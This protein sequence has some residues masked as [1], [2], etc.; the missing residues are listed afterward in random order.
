MRRETKV[1]IQGLAGSFHD[2]VAR[3][4]FGNNRINV[5][6]ASSFEGV[7]KILN[8]DNSIHYGVMAIENSIAG[9]LLQNYR[10]LRENDF[11]ISG[12]IYHKIQHQLLA[13][14]GQ[15]IEDINI[16]ESHPMALLQCTNFLSQ[17]EHIKVIESSNTAVS[18]KKISDNQLKGTAT[19]ASN[20]AAD[21]YGLEKLFENVQNKQINYTRFVVFSREP[22]YSSIGVADK[23]SIYI[24]VPHDKGSLL[25]AIQ[26]IARHDINISKLQSYPVSGELNTYYFH[27]DLEFKNIN[28]YESCIEDL[29]Q[30]TT[31][32]EE[33]GVYKNGI[34]APSVVVKEAPVLL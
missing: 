34:T 12:E 13:L 30:S 17:Y 20:T 31:A 24:R 8:Q 32:L 7:A 19:I 25:K 27:I 9:S 15:S 21:I 3:E 22:Q 26:D 28:Q 23:A 29:K 10:I 1:V 33:L 14:P 4:Y 6:S 11:W 16:V 18:A 5:V 2:E